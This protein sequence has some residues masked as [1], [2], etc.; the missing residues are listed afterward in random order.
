M[1]LD[2]L[3][4]AWQE[5]IKMKEKTIDFD[6]IRLEADKYDRKMSLGWALELAACAVL[7]IW[8]VIWFN[9]VNS[10]NPVLLSGMAVMALTVIYVAFKIIKGR[11][12]TTSD[13]W[14]LS[15]RIN[16]QIDKREQEKALFSSVLYWY[17]SPILLAVL[18][19]SYGGYI[20]RTD[21]YI[22]DAGLWLY[23]GVCVVLFVGVYFFNIHRVKTKVEPM[24]E[25]LH[26]LKKELEG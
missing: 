26:K 8:V 16:I 12:S 13:D 23:W 10:P 19:G 3:K 21:S 22:P 1:E 17:L 15:A 11:K 20:Q 9:K 25:K 18:L 4:A 5:E 14:T 2:D 24:L 6:S 7:L